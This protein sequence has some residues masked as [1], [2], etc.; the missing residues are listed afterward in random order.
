[1]I[2]YAPMFATGNFHAAHSG[3]HTK[4]NIMTGNTV[5]RVARFAD[6]KVGQT[7]EQVYAYPNGTTITRVGVVSEVAEGAA[8]DDSGVW[9]VDAEGDDHPHATLRILAD[10]TPKP[11]KTLPDWGVMVRVI[12]GEL[13]GKRAVAINRDDI[14]CPWYVEGHGWVGSAF[15]TDWTVIHDPN[16]PKDV[17]ADAPKADPLDE[18][19]HRDRLTADGRRIVW[20]G[21]GHWHTPAIHGRWCGH[22]RDNSLANWDA[23]CGPLRF[24]D[25]VTS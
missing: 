10:P 5:P 6:I 24:A 11:R 20:H 25:E 12:G 15:I 1:M 19:D 14:L 17:A 16:A 22:C 18:S 9:M 13:G 8:S 4:D 3:T 23:V 21:R 7:V 2:A